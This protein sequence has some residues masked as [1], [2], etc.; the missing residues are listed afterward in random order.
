MEIITTPFGT[1]ADNVLVSQYTIRAADGAEV[2]ILD[3]GCTIR[4]I[5]VPDRD[6]HLVDV[7]LGYDTIGE[8]ETNNG[9]FG[10]VIGRHANR[11]QAGCFRLNGEDYRLVCN[12]GPN[13]LHG[14]QKGFDKYVWA[15]EKLSNGVRFL[16]SFPDGDEGYPGNLDV[17]V[18]YTWEDGHRLH[19][20]Y[21]AVS[22]RDTVLNMT[23]HCYF[24][25]S[26][27]GTIRN[28]ELCLY[29]SHF[30]KNDK[31]CLPDGCILPVAGTP[32]DFTLPKSIGCDLDR[33]EPQLLWCGGYDHNFIL[34]DL[35]NLKK[36]GWLWSPQT[37]I[38]MDIETT[39]PGIQLYTG[40]VLTDRM[41]KDGR[42][43]GKN[44]ALC[45]ETQHFP[46]SMAHPNFPSV[47]LNKGEKYR[48]DTIYIFS[49]E[50]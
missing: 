28:H 18:T 14:G 12:D 40:N 22:D 21:E 46:N 42:L 47:I 17:C 45:L 30:T 20:H 37:G 8:Y 49:T 5:Q 23:N 29:S 26:G 6:G 27:E 2:Q 24:N 16:H 35:G 7:C 13:H 33:Q 11:I 9:Y 10:A 41:G 1:T 31:N 36:A 39:Q 4:S 32:F 38:R 19:L 34:D 15:A 50:R 48:Q 3:Y 43:Y 25:L 44:G